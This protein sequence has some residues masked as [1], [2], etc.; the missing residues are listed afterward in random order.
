MSHTETGR[1][2]LDIRY[3]HA[4]AG[5]AAELAPLI[6]E[7]SH[8]LLDFMFGDRAKAEKALGRLIDRPGGHFSYRFVRRMLLDDKLCGAELGYGATQLAAEETAG[9]I[10]MLR[11]MPCR[12]WPHPCPA[13]QCLS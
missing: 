10:N 8:E 1:A 2:D 5:Q 3:E 12:R 4:V 9:A 7:S 11:A 6:Y 13:P